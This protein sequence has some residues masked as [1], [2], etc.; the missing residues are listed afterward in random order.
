MHGDLCGPIS[1]STSGGNRYIFVLIDDFSRVMW[2][3]LLKN[4]S[5]T[6]DAFKR[7]CVLVENSSGKKVKTFRTDNG[8]EF[9][10]KDFNKFCEEAGIN[11]HFSA[12]YSPQQNGVVER[13]NRTLIEM[14]RSL[15]KEMK[16]PNY[17]WGEA[18]RHS[19]YLLNRLPTRAVTGI[20]PYEAW[21][22]NKPSIDHIRVFGCLAH[23]KEP[24]VNLKKLDDRSRTVVYLGKEPGVK[25]YRLLDPDTKRIYVSRDVVFEEQKPWNWDE[26]EESPSMHT[27]S[28][29]VFT[30]NSDG[31]GDNDTVERT[32][33]TYIG[34]D[35]ED[36]NGNS[37]QNSTVSSL[38]CDTDETPQKYRPLSEVYDSTEPIE[39]EDA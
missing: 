33:R 11:R 19:T 24:S 5:E 20:T 12:P 23:M 28:F 9:T 21:S 37:V 25:A 35:L 39:M 15:L 31:N 29:S 27:G 4:K 17:L 30:E 13:R 6:L 2:T 26:T 32:P 7:F 3:Y 34:N 16:M 36:T 10:S 1:P 22:N 18:V 14:A 38:D 8:G